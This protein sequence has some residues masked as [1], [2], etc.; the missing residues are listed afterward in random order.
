MKAQLFHFVTN[1]AF[2]R[3]TDK[4]TDSFLGARPHC[5]HCMQ[6]M[7]RLHSAL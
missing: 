4:Q 6:C 2:D 1:R 7:H 3:Q 5:M